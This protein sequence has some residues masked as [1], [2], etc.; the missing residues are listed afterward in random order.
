MQLVQALRDE[1][2][3]EELTLHLGIDHRALPDDE[4]V[5]VRVLLEAD[6]RADAVTRELGRRGHD[7]VDDAR[8]LLACHSG[9][10]RPGADAHEAAPDVVL[11]DDDDD[12]DDRREQR[13][14]QV[15][16]G[17]EAGPLR[18]DVDEED[19][20]EPGAHLHRTRATEHEERA[21]DDIRDDEEV[22]DVYEDLEDRARREQIPEAF[23]HQ[24]F[25]RGVPRT[26]S[27]SMA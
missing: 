17:D 24:I 3:D 1:H 8:L 26:I 10:E 9:E 7:L 25:L 21:V 5:E 16:E 11:E 18:D 22:C 12:Q 19:D 2:A 4:L 6:E 14:E 27:M 23:Q 20:T 13:R 15:E